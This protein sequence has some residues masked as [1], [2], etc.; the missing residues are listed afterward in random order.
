MTHPGKEA[1]SI[2]LEHIDE[3]DPDAVYIDPVEYSL[4]PWR[5]NEPKGLRRPKASEIKDRLI[6]I[7]KAKQVLP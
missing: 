1:L 5:A 7:L 6:A 3:N 2:L 4:A